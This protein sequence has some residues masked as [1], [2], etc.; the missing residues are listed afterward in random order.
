MQHG[1]G[2]EVWAKFRTRPFP[3]MKPIDSLLAL[4]ALPAPIGA[5][6]CTNKARIYR[7]SFEVADFN[8]RSA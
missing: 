2:G 7:L 3:R 4:V 8:A 5:V 6:A 1:L